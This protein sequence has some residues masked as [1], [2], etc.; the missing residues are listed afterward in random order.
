MWVQHMYIRVGIAS[1]C[2]HNS[3]NY[4]HGSANILFLASLKE[5]FV[6]VHGRDKIK[7][8]YVVDVKQTAHI[9]LD[10]IAKEFICVS[11][12]SNDLILVVFFWVYKLFVMKYRTKK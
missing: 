2:S 8:W 5:F 11:K 7:S 12:R 3:G 4:C 6:V 1:R 10:A 9:D